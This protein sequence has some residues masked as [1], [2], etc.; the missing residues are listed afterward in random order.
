MKMIFAVLRKERMAN[1]VRLINADA[2]MKSMYHRAFE[3]DGDTMWQSGCWVRYRAIEQ[4]VKEQPTV[5]A[6]PVRHGHWIHD[7]LDIPHGVDWMHCS[8]CGKRD[9]YC[10]AA[11]TNYCPNCGARMD[12]ENDD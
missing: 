6:H 8:E 3:T 2:L 7:G 1:R 11:M 12:G 9:K 10:P 5:D 4:A